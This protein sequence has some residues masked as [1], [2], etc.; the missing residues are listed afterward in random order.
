M[1]DVMSQSDNLTIPL[2]VRGES[3]TV[4]Y[5]SDNQDCLEGL[6]CLRLDFESMFTQ[7]EVINFSTDLSSLEPVDLSLLANETVTDKTENLLNSLS[8]L[9]PAFSNF[10]KS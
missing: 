9:V 8:S 7:F 3:T 4:A 6:E 5:V 2:C 10:K 1:D